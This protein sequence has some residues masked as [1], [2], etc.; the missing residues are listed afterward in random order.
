MGDGQE[1][2]GGVAALVSSSSATQGRLAR[3][4]APAATSAHQQ[5]PLRSVSWR[6]EQPEPAPLSAEV[7]A[8]V[9]GGTDAGRDADCS[10]RG[11]QEQQEQPQIQDQRQQQLEGPSVA[12]AHA[13]NQPLAGSHAQ[14][15]SLMSQWQAADDA[16]EDAVVAAGAAST[17]ASSTAHPPAEVARSVAADSCELGA[18][19][20]A[21]PQA[22][23]LQ[24]QAE[25]HELRPRSG[26]AQGA[27]L[28]G[29]LAMA[30][31]GMEAAGQGLATG[32]AATLAGAAGLPGLLGRMVVTSP[33]AAAERGEW[34]DDEDEAAQSV[35]KGEEGVL[36]R[37]Q[38]IAI[39]DRA[40]QQQQ[41][42]EAAIAAAPLASG[43][44]SGGAQAEQMLGAV[45]AELQS[46]RQ[47]L[48]AVRR[49][50]H[51]V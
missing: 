6:D 40:M 51:P 44:G 15:T 13:A 45:L 31:R 35:I 37:H 7:A 29:V 38:A 22:A 5:L 30:G 21:A 11:D 42:E 28:Q 14:H 1:G 34:S 18:G 24:Q 49:Q 48:E 16:V 32:A 27:A 17:A 12:W 3:A 46:L 23:V 25:Q 9:R 2:S 4:S 41:D 10:G 50:M 20:H 47:D 19:S 8:G 36:P 26:A 43:G 33:V 39:L